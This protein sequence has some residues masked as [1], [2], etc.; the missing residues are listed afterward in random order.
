[1][2]IAPFDKGHLGSPVHPV[3]HVNRELPLLIRGEIVKGE[4]SDWISSVKLDQDFLTVLCEI[5]LLDGSK[6]LHRL[7]MRNTCGHVLACVS[8]R[9]KQ[10]LKSPS[11]C[12]AL[13]TAER[14]VDRNYNIPEP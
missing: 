12:P 11:R 13:Y 9:T 10:T 8:P 7:F 4:N 3:I 6:A 14:Y 1:V 2:V 5:G